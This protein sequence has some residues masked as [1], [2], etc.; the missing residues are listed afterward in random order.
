MERRTGF[1]L[2][3]LLVVIGIIAILAAILFPVFAQARKQ[4]QDT[5]CLSNLRQI[6]MA[7]IMYTQDYDDTYFYNLGPR[8]TPSV[9]DDT[10]A[11]DPSVSPAD[12]SNRWDPSPIIPVLN[13]YLVSSNIWHCPA[14]TTPYINSVG[15]Q[16]ENIDAAATNY[17]VNAY[18]VVDSIPTGRPTPVPQPVRTSDV[19]NPTRIKVFQDYWNQGV[20]PHFNGGNYVCVDGHAK[21]QRNVGAGKGFI[22]A[23]WWTP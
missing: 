1:T 13:S 14:L 12:L 7:T 17:Q 15:V 20:N 6:G 18:L 23:T 9:T 8:F 19:V 3:E 11:R 4:A 5:A 22:I 21:W 2:I 16:Q 10:L